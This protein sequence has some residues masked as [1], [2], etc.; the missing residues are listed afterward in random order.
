LCCCL[1]AEEEEEEKKGRGEDGVRKE[2][3]RKGTERWRRWD[4][5]RAEEKEKGQ[6][7]PCRLSEA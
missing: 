7:G 5:S 3:R 1:A 4:R 6:M 2:R